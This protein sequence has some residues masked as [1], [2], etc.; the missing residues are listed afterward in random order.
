MAREF[1]VGD[2]VWWEL[3]N[4]GEA[5]VTKNKGTIDLIYG[6]VA[7]VKSGENYFLTPISW[8]HRC[9]PKPKSVRVTR[10]KLAMAWDVIISP[11][12]NFL[13]A[14]SSCYFEDMCKLLGLEE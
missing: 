4:S 8:L 14:N 2:R 13:S 10:E 6:R 9:K 7:K 12:S 1:K 3:K 5:T 11:K